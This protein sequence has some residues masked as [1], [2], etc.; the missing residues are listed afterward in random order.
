[1]SD[2]LEQQVQKPVELRDIVKLIET[3]SSTPTDSP[4]NV[5]E[6]IRLVVAGGVASLYVYDVTNNKWRAASLGT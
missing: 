3:R 5:H 4:R 6:Q 1:M 2:N